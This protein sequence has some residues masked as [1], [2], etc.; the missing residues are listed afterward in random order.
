MNGGDHALRI[1]HSEYVTRGTT[2]CNVR[3]SRSFSRSNAR[4]I[5]STSSRLCSV[6]KS[7][8]SHRAALRATEARIGASSETPLFTCTPLHVCD[9]FPGVRVRGTRG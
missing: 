7:G 9:Q 8:T 4:G 1:Q 6:R 2:A 5:R 3:G